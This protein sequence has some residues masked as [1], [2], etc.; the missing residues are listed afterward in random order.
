MASEFAE[1]GVCVFIPPSLMTLMLVSFINFTQTGL[2]SSC[3][4]MSPLIFVQ[5]IC[6]LMDH[7]YTSNEESSKANSDADCLKNFDNISQI[8][9][10]QDN[11]NSEAD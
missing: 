1:E 7:G 8:Q 4:P 2:R 10:Q 11:S 9:Y 6:L 5:S 3:R